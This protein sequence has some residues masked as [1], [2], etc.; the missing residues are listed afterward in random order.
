MG[1]MALQPL[2]VPRLAKIRLTNKTLVLF[3]VLALIGIYYACFR[4]IR[5]DC[6]RAVRE[7]SDG[8]AVAVCEREYVRT[9]DPDTGIRFANALM[10]SNDLIAASAI[11]TSLTA[12]S[13]GG[14]AIQTLGKI[15]DVQSRYDD[16]V[17]LLHTARSIHV[18]QRN[19]KSLAEDDHQLAR[20]YYRQARYADA[21]QAADDCL[22]EAVGAGDR[23]VE[24]YCHLTA[25]HVLSVAGYFE[26]AQIELDHA[27][28]LLTEHR[29]L[30]ALASERGDLYQNY[31][32]GPLHQNF[33]ARAVEEYEKAIAHT[34]FANHPQRLQQ[35]ELNL[36]FSL[37]E[38]G[39]FDEAT[40][41][42]EIERRLDLDGRNANVCSALE[43]KI[44]YQRGNHALAFTINERVYPKLEDG[45]NKLN[46][47]LMQARIALADGDPKLAEI[48]ANRSVEMMERRLAKSVLEMRPWVLSNRRQ[49]YE[50]LFTVL[51]RQHR[52]ADA[53][54]TLDQWHGRTLL[55]ALS[56]HAAEPS[57]LRNAS[58]HTESLRQIFPVWSRTPLMHTLDRGQLLARLA[59]VD[60]LAL[61]V[62]EGEVWRITAHDQA[63]DIVDVGKFDPLAKQIA[64]LRTTP[65]DRALAEA[66]GPQLL[67][68]EA[69]RA[70]PE[71][72]H[73]VL[74]GELAGLPVVALRA[75][76]QPLIAL[77]AVVQPPRLSEVDC[78][79]PLPAAPRVAVYADARGDLPHARAAATQIAHRFDVEPHLGSDATRDEVLAADCD[80]LHV[81][82][83]GK[84][85]ISGGALDLHDGPLSALEIISRHTPPLVVL[86]ACDSA[87]AEDS[88]HATSLSTAFLSGGS[89]QVIATLRPVT[90]AGARDVVHALYES[91]MADPVRALQRAQAKLAET[92]NQEWANFAIFGHDTCRKES[93]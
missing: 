77:R 71:T 41:H 34:R 20:T 67:G 50:L 6:A 16:A 88:E 17:Q 53:L 19:I 46:V 35:Y 82:V 66:L 3:G 25:A 36:V 81:A 93:L 4:T 30:A 45:N 32:F 85:G 22:R 91:S 64:T 86:T 73:V 24:G 10:G 33:Q 62:A 38:I 58:M 18:E 89:Q 9:G 8:V 54:V 29:D 87:N 27:E 55:D 65:T 76:G 72:L 28:P 40:H 92:D 49:P 31:Q 14:D 37:T 90:D 11:A 74:D 79:P 51:V 52:F 5:L 26:S 23:V 60:V 48:W 1:A 69:F 68:A 75:H 15:A 56:E 2:R 63:I 78:V 80:L 43:A 12:S 59:H 70:T 61:A 83:H 21:L 47:A 39:N 42:L 84:V 13:A 7:A 57:S 44:A